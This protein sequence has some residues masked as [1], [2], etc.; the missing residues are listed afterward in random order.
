MAEVFGAASAATSLLETV[1]SLVA[2]LRK[3]YD[4]HK[5]FPSILASYAQELESI[6]KIIDMV[7]NQTCLR[8]DNI[9]AELVRL[10]TIEERML[11]WLKKANREG[12]GSIQQFSRHLVHGSKYERTL[13]E[14]MSE[15]GRGKSSLCLHIQIAAIGVTRTLENTFSANIEEITRINTML[16]QILG[17][18]QGLRIAAVLKG[19]P[20]RSDGTVTLS[21]KDVASLSSDDGVS[22][23]DP[24]AG[25]SPRRGTAGSVERII[26]NNT[27]EPLALMVNGPIGEDLYRHVSRLEVKDNIAKEEDIQIN[28]ATSMNDF[29][30]IMEQ[31]KLAI[32]MKY[33]AATGPL[34]T[35]NVAQKMTP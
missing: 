14:I 17:H 32:A 13:A 28:Y 4:R 33:G 29:Q 18:G 23:D 7:V 20:R 9:A 25:A 24:D 35:S 34:L 21:S 31:R 12:K 6:R 16:V 15:L 30:S 2:I 10:Q 8:T 27:T 3:A 11:G 1:I 5:E 19:R 22:I 26:C